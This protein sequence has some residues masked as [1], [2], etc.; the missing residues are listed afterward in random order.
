MRVLTLLKVCHC[1][2]LLK[3]Q[4]VRI[5]STL[6]LCQSG[7]YLHG[8][9][10][11]CGAIKKGPVWTW[12]ALESKSRSILNVYILYIYIYMYIYMYVY[13]YIVIL[14]YIIS[15]YIILYDIIYIYYIIYYILYIIYYI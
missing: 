1:D 3:V 4:A 15:Y 14:Y 10:W 5:N 2:L 13:I 11:E 12:R 7:M 8:L 9:G 6:L